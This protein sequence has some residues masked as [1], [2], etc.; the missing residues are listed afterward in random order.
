MKKLFFLL[1]TVCSFALAVSAQTRTIK[2]QVVY[3]GD[4]EPLVG[5]TILPVGGGQGVSTNIDGEFTLIIPEKVKLVTVSY[6]GMITQQVAVAPEML[7]KMSNSDNQLDEVVVTAMGMKRE[8]KALGYAVQD[9]KSDDLNTDGTTSIASAIQGKLTGVDIRPSS[10]MPG[11]SANIVIRG[12]RSFDGNNAPLYVVDGMPITTEADFSTLDSVT[13]ANIADRSIDINPEDIESVNVLKGQA[14]AALYGIRASNG[15]IVI[16]TKRGAGM[17][18]T[19][20]VVTV[21]TNMSAERVSRK[22]KRQTKYSQSNGKQYDDDGNFIGWYDPSASMSWGPAISDLPND[23]NFGGNVDNQY[24]QLYGK[25]EGMYYN[26]KRVLAGLDGWE[27]PTI[28]DNVGDFYQTGFTENANFNISQRLDRASYSFGLNNSYQKGI[29]PSTGMKRWGARGLVDWQINDQWKTGFSVNYSSTYITS[30]PSAND[31]IMNVV[32]SAPAEYNLKGIPYHVPGHPSQQISFRS[33]SFNNP[34]WWAENN[35][36]EQNTNRVFGNAYMEY[37][38]KID[39]GE[40]FDLYFREQAGIDMYTS[41]YSDVQEVGSGAATNG[42]IENRGVE[43]NIFN[44]LFTVNFNAKFGADK[45]WDLQVLLGNEV[46]HENMRKWEYTGTNFNFY[47]HPT[48]G[49]ATN[50]MA[51]EYNRSKRT[52]G[53][54]GSASLS[55]ENQLYLT[56]TGRNDYV[57]T[58]PRN[59]RSFFYP[60]VSLAWLFTELPV[61]KGNNIFTFGKLRASFAQVG[62][63]GEYYDNFYWTPEYGSGMYTFYPITYPMNGVSTFVPY[64]ILFDPNLKPQNT[65]NY[66]IGADLRFF[67][68]RLRVDYTF[69]NQDIKDQIFD[70]PSDG[71]TGYQYMRTNAGRMQTQS[72][73]LAINGAILQGKDYSLDLGVNFTRVWNYVKELAPGV[74]SIMLGGFAEPQIRAQAGDTYPI[75]YG[76]AFKRDENGNLLLKNG[77]PQ[78]TGDSQ[79]IGEC[80]PDFTMGINLG[81]RYKRVSISTTWSWQKGGQMYSGTNLV[82]NM[83]GVTKETE[84][85]ENNFVIE[86][87]DE[88]TGQKNTTEA[89]MY[90]YW[91]IAGDIS[92]AAIYDTSFFKLRDVTLTYNLPKIG[93][94][95]IS[96]FGFARNVLIWAK[97]PNLDP[98][99]SQGNNNMGGYFERFS[100]PNTSSYGAGLKVT[101]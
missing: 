9:L 20:P 68:D 92:E 18:S 58:M 79:K 101:F 13:G 60:S 72:H 89:N 35:K 30:A 6:V 7:I 63:A 53:F 8:R 51:K 15:V 70:V 32:Y 24:T 48:I 52:V 21:S 44:N 41:N 59:S 93:I 17:Q 88:A 97:M 38:P 82:M 16:T 12:A 3:A 1:L 87:I 4:N 81:G 83:F 66:E 28:Y 29:I 50:Y 19:K 42:Q 94:F 62:Q 56:V 47:G 23:M 34:Y 96:V 99:S 27:R 80:T 61:F 37:R 14:A 11:A 46:N 73:E 54:F 75:I 55:W 39:W 91:Q 45:E 36:Y 65:T 69:S 98:E 74:E 78:G 57:S 5:A 33:T 77:L 76:N 26:P 22:F 43:K 86:G 71:A 10:G 84:N 90:D 31:G 25:H 2:G 67:N 64:Y 85:R 100:V 40:N 49:N 95:D